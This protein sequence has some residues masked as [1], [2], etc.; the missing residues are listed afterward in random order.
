MSVNVAT[1]FVLDKRRFYFQ[2]VWESSCFDLSITD[3][4]FAWHVRADADF[5]ERKLKPRGMD[6]ARYIA[7]LRNGLTKQDIGQ[8]KFTYSAAEV[9]NGNLRLEWTM[10]IGSQASAE[11]PLK[12][13]GLLELVRMQAAPQQEFIQTCLDRLLDFCTTLERDNEELREQHDEL[14][15]QRTEALSKLVKLDDDKQRLELDLYKKFVTLINEKK[16]KV[17]QLKG[18]LQAAESRAMEAARRASLAIDTASESEF[19]QQGLSPEQTAASFDEDNGYSPT[20]VTDYL[21]LS[22]SEPGTS[23]SVSL[24]LQSASVDLGH[25]LEESYKIPTRVRKR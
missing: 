18:Q 3:G 17:R 9:P 7:E 21:S 22:Q 6:S 2:S 11:E 16:K 13:R 4:R 19:E 20:P 25:D 24:T 12:L 5:I 15:V 14:R 23:G 8:K 1:R 10:R